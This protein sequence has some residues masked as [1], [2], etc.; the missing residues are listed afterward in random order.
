MHSDA[1]EEEENG[2]EEASDEDGP[3]IWD[4]MSGEDA[5]ADEDDDFDSLLDSMEE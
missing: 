4:T 3:D 2:S 5:E 1:S